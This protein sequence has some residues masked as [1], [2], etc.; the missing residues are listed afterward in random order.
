MNRVVNGIYDNVELGT[1]IFLEDKEIDIIIG[2]LD[3]YADALE[4]SW[5]SQGSQGNPKTQ[6]FAKVRS[7]KAAVLRNRG[8]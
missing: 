6:K 4:K 2:W 8:N 1:G 5:E 7:F 3:S